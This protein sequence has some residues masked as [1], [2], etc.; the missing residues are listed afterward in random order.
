MVRIREATEEDIEAIVDLFISNYGAHYA[1]PEFHSRR[2]LKRLVYTDDTLI[3]VAED[4]DSGRILGT[5]SVVL[6]FGAFGDLL[7]E[8][9]RLV[10]HPDGRK[11]GIGNKLMDAR[12]EAVQDRLHIAVVENRAAHPFS[13]RI[14][15]SHGFSC[16]GF[17]PCKVTFKERES[18]AYYAKHF[19]DALEL[20]RNHPRLIP[21]TYEL[22]DLV[23]RS[24]ELSSDVIVDRE[25]PAYQNE[26]EF[27]LEDMTSRG[28]ASLLRF[29]RGRV[30]RREVFGPVKLHVG[31]FQLHVSDY[32]YVLA[33]LDGRLVGGLGYHIDRVENAA[34]MLELVSADDGP[35]RTLLATV[36]RRCLE[37]EGIGYI[38]ADVSAYSPRMLRTFLE[39]GY[40]PVAYIPAMAFHRVER[41]DSVRMARLAEPPDTSSIELHDAT[42][43]VAEIVMRQFR[44]R[45]IAPRLAKS[46]PTSAVFQ[47][48]N[49][50]QTRQ[51]G[52]VCSLRVYSQGERLVE[53]GAESSQAML[54][55][56]GSVSVSIDGQDVGTVGVGE[57]SGEGSLLRN[58]PHTATA[59]ALEAVEAAVLG[60]DEM[61]SLVRRRP[62][63]GLI[64][65]RN[66]AAQLGEKLTRADRKLMDLA[67]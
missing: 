2:V 61:E 4:A 29:E 30:S 9:G 65:Y 25:S 49:S 67:D 55:L 46:I 63:I 42:K 39:L 27:D 44:E 23:L 11:M 50:E 40:L 15:S 24:C 62:D 19:G 48:L 58:L 51:L 6:D 35:I 34:R 41:L 7:G 36:T 64:L 17:L 3:F 1:H 8:F 18:I 14:S 52:A 22:A 66:L 12:L 33:K 45:E 59:M 32:R 26:F 38:E 54:I 21:E 13:Q 56:S 10:V 57:S 60:R 37:E 31:L 43:P 47:G 5:G 20:R 53:Q 28:Y 16:A